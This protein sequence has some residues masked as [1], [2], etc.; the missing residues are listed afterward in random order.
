MAIGMGR[1]QFISA[2]GGAAV[3]L[4]LA[5]RAQQASAVRR[6]GVLMPGVESDINTQRWIRAFG[7]S[8]REVSIPRQSRGL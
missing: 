8:L 5:A 1:R 4:P 3:A 7:K 6:I 2:F